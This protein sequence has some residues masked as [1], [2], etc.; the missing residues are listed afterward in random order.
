[1]PFEHTIW[2]TSFLISS[3]K[4]KMTGQRRDSSSSPRKVFR[5]KKRASAR[6]KTALM[7]RHRID[8]IGGRRSLF[9][10]FQEGVL[11]GGTSLG[12][13]F[14]QQGRGG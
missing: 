10:T 11:R 3:G 14:F 6:E 13:S 8:S 5:S 2:K 4:E 7:S 12:T 1:M 9:P